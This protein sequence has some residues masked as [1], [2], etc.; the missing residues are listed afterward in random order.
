ME[1]IVH[2]S[3]RSVCSRCPISDFLRRRNNMGNFYFSIRCPR[4]AR[5]RAP[6]FNIHAAS[7]EKQAENV[8]KR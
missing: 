4:R 6:L 3:T 8:S 1:A 5:A 2:N 7:L